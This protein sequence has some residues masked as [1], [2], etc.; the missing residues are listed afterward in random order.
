MNTRMLRNP[1]LAVCLFAA[2]AFAAGCELDELCG[3]GKEESG[4]CPNKCPEDCG[5][6]GGGGAEGEG[7][8]EGGGGGGG[9]GGGEGE[10]EAAC[11][12]GATTCDANG[13]LQTCAGGA[14]GAPAPC[15]NGKTCVQVDPAVYDA[16]CDW[17]RDTY[18]WLRVCSKTKRSDAA[19]DAKY[20]GPDIDAVE[21]FDAAGTLK[22]V[23]ENAGP[24]NIQEEGNENGDIN[25]CLGAPDAT[26]GTGAEAA[27]CR[28]FTSIGLKGHWVTVGTA[29]DIVPTDKIVVHEVPNCRGDAADT[30]S[31]PSR[32][33]VAVLSEN[34]LW[35]EVA[36][37]FQGGQGEFTVAADPGV[38]TS[39]PC[40]PCDDEDPATGCKP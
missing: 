33:D 15:D 36:S 34:G 23:G 17:V 2:A 38:G 28:G 5:G 32:I 27:N 8:G 19:Y 4:E 12:D 9:G 29:F 40:E 14:W 18:R 31:E 11:T 1:L 16:A 13:D 37:D 3:N 25:E 35:Y 21:V 30:R 26:F 7:E 20:T 6:G 22:G 10:G 24:S 39:N